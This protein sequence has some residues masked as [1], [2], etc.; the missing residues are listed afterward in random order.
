MDGKEHQVRALSCCGPCSSLGGI[1]DLVEGISSPRTLTR[2]LSL[3]SVQISI[4]GTE[5]P[6]M[7]Q[8]TAC[9]CGSHCEALTAVSPEMASSSRRINAEQKQ[10]GVESKMFDSRAGRALA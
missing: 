5:R 4:L 9:P 6:G 8:S 7:V 1:P 10:M 2:K 3:L